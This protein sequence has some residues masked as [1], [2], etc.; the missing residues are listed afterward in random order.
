M[1]EWLARPQ[2]YAR[3]QRERYGDVFTAR[4]DR[5]FQTPEEF[6][7]LVVAKGADGVVVRLGD[8]ARVELGAEEDRNIFR[9]NGRDAVGLGIVKQST[10]NVVEVSQLKW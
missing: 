2:V 1:S 7:Q 5:P 10:A 9:A 3:R 6:A 8:I 4:I